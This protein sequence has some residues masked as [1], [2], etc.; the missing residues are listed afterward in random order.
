MRT[1]SRMQVVLAT[2]ALLATAICFVLPMAALAVPANAPSNAAIEAKRAEADQARQKQDDLAAALETR[3]EEYQQIEDALAKTD[4]DI[5]VT[6]ADLAVA[7]S[8]EASAKALL[9]RR[10]VSIYRNGRMD[11]VSVLM[12]VTDFQDLINRLDLMRRVGRNDAAL[13]AGVEDARSRVETARRSLETR[14]EEQVVLRTGA[15]EKASQ[16]ERALNAQKA[17][18]AT[19]DAQLKQLIA[20]ERARQERLARERAAAAAARAIAK[21]KLLPFDES[22]LGAPHPEAVEAAKRFLGV[23]YVWGGTSPSGFDCSGLTQYAYG[24]VGIAIPRTSRSQFGTGAYIPPNRQDLLAPG[25]LLFFGYDADW[26]QI[27]HVG[28]Y[29]GNGEF[30]HAPQADDVVRIASLAARIETRGDFVGACRP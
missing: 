6:E 23:P 9:N 24:S 22:K 16:V 5:A 18:L 11:I 26:E 1:R 29:I 27:H 12:G 21:A 2:T 30:I 20:D 19:L 3:F 15:A 14:R 25:D 7:R 4:R 17:F 28:M 13:V 8:E 10:A